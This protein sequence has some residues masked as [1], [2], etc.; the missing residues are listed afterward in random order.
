MFDLDRFDYTVLGELFDRLCG[1]HAFLSFMDFNTAERPKRFVLVR[2]DIDFCP[3][4][5][6]RMAEFEAERGIQATYFLMFSSPFYN[7]QDREL[8]GF[9]RRLV[10]LGHEVGLHYDLPALEAAGDA[11]TVRN[12]AQRQVEL[13]ETLSG[14]PVR[15]VAQHNP[16]LRSGGDPVAEAA[17]FV[18]AYDPAFTKDMPYFSDSCGAWRTA[19]FEHLSA[20]RFPD[21]LQLLLHPIFWDETPGQ[22]WG[23]LEAFLRERHAGLDREYAQV[24]QIWERH[25]GLLEHEQRLAQARPNNS[26]EE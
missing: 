15:S 12:L 11:T 23:R 9:P 22:R 13:L 17:R 1:T 19:T 7:L 25:T 16:S 3:A 6:L 26:A 24:R 4:A 14:M 10:G 5:A 2:H 8:A 21:K 18:N 20:G